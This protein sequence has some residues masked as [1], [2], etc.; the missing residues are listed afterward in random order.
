MLSMLLHMHQPDYRDPR[1]G[2]PCM[3]WVR[4][5]ATRGY[6]DVPK[7]ILE[8]GARVTVNLVPS[9]L[10]QWEHY[11]LGGSDPWLTLSRRRA[12]ELE[13]HEIAWL[14]AN[15]FA[16]FPG[17]FHWF[18]AWG[19]L[20]ARHAARDRL[21]AQDLRDVIVWSNL[22]WFG[23]SAL[24]DFPELAALRKKAR[25]FTEAEQQRV[26]DIQLAI[27]RDL[28]RLYRALPEV[29]AT[30]ACHPILPLLIDT[31][32]ARRCMPD[33]PDPG[34]RWPEDAEEHLR[35]ARA[36]VTAFA[37]RVVD[38]LWP[39]E[40]SVSP[41][42]IEIAAATGFRWFATDQGV[43]E[44][45]ARD[46]NADHHGAWEVGRMRGLFRDRELSDRIGFL[47]G[48]WKGEEAAADLV[49]R[50][51]RAPVLL[52]LDG[53]NPWETY[54]D[55][56]G[57]FLRALFSRARTRTCGEMALDTPRGRVT[58]LHTGSWIGADFRIWIGHPEDRAA[59]SLLVD[60]R[61]EWDRR[62][63]PAAARPH[64][65]AAEGSD[66]FWW[67]GEEFDT[68]FASEFDRLFRAHLAAAWEGMGGPVPAVLSEPIKRAVR[69]GLSPPRAALPADGDD[70]FAW[71]SAGRL[72]LRAGAMAPM[73]GL[74][75]A[76]LFGERDGA[77]HLRLLPS[78][79]GWAAAA[80]GVR[81]PFQAG[82]AR[83]PDPGDG[84]V[85]EGPHG[86]RVPQ[87]GALALPWRARL[88]ERP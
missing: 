67:Y 26:L 18:P 84:V 50:L 29:S 79:E 38:G 72:D 1:T 64:L 87:E 24:E 57:R 55:A 54:P 62:G 12:E 40:G 11:A 16:G 71:A 61:A 82:T 41:E 74:P 45:S 42:V 15:F 49:A 44:R 53:E 36:R 65:L 8:T 25:G 75:Q 86:L 69:P 63:R 10:D 13:P 19:E 23:F 81:V 85:L 32:H 46:P 58:T 39:S 59:W 5:H 60:A 22:M 34:F 56:G 21:S 27:V 30:P 68:P 66:W 83:L 70:W 48:S 9:L 17:A 88:P 77:L 4:L 37:G 76:L 28:P 6:R 43:L 20:K 3:P 7:V 31:A 14:L 33:V 52:A 51:P 73:R 35:I 78:G 2:A 47:Y 80:N